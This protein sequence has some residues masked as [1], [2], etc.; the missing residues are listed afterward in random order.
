[1]IFSNALSPLFHEWQQ[2]GWCGAW[3]REVCKIEERED[4]PPEDEQDALDRL[5]RK[6][7]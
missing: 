1:L 5:R 6:M 3:V 4:E 2:C 7:D